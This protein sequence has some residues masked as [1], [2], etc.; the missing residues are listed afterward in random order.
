M[1]SK[2][3]SPRPAPDT[4]RLVYTV[5]Q[6]NAEVR[7]VLEQALPSLWIQGEISNLARP[8]SGHLYFSLKDDKAQVRCAMWRQRGSGLG[9]T[10]KNGQQVVARARVGLYEPRG[11]YQLIVEYMEEAGEGLLRQQL[12]AL[13]ARLAAEGLFDELRK[14]PLPALPRR[15]GV[16]T[17]PSG[18]AVRDVLKV[19]RRRFP[20]I[21][22]L[23]YPVPVQ[24]EGAAEQIARAI[25]LAN[26]RAEC[27]V[28]ILTRGGGSL[29][30]LWAFNE[31]PVARAVFN[32]RIPLVS[33]VGHEIDV[34]VSDL[35]ADVRAPTPSAAAELVVPDRGEWLRQLDVTLARMASLAGRLHHR[36]AEKLAWLA[37]RLRRR[38]PRQQLQQDNQRLDELE[39]RARRAA[40][41]ALRRRQR[42]LSALNARFAAASPARVVLR[43]SERFRDMERRLL[44][45]SRRRLVQLEGQLAATARELNALSPLAV[46]GRGFALVFDSKGRLVSEATTLAS[47]DA[48]QARLARGRILAR[49]TGVSED[50]ENPDRDR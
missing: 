8:A 48:I 16:I 37:G 34:T 7:Q 5:S 36:Q 29:E 38:D 4:G 44:S 22:V 25:E 18:A 46:L 6:L 30:D 14:Q 35:V 19:L 20:A 27:D 32:S 13:K 3:A 40:R 28:L 45:A 24:G 9:F 50:D 26:T 23:I 15:I 31:E 11:E 47:G 49:V 21:P 12:E 39:L 2:P 17:S 41:A 43:Q 42:D 33:A 10:P 1:P